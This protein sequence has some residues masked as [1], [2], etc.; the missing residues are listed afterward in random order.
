MERILNLTHLS[1]VAPTTSHPQHDKRPRPS[2]HSSDS[3]S[4]A[5]H[6][7]NSSS[8]LLDFELPMKRQVVES[9]AVRSDMMSLAMTQV[10]HVNTPAAID[11]SPGF[12]EYLLSEERMDVSSASDNVH[13]VASLPITVSVGQGMFTNQHQHQQQ[14]QHL[15]PCTYPRGECLCLEES[16]VEAGATDMD[17]PCSLV[18]GDNETVLDTVFSSALM[19]RLY[20]EGVPAE[21]T[22]PCQSTPSPHHS[23]TTYN[24]K[25]E[26]A[27]GSQPNGVPTVTQRATARQGQTG[28]GKRQPKAT[29]PPSTTAPAISRPKGS[30]SRSLS[31]LSVSST[32]SSNVPRGVTSR[33][34]EA[35]KVVVKQR[36]GSQAAEISPVLFLNK[37]LKC[38]NYSSDFTRSQKKR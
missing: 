32:D 17:Y 19:S 6:S 2:P 34:L 36:L 37:M 10:P 18:S 12:P 20:E 30:S 35:D 29:A 1:E 14:Q 5:L 23:F 8:T 38:R 33:G 27:V 4:H 21:N 15:L 22:P 7:W 13:V 3:A 31:S 24:P 25:N 11:A 28:R 9:N 16:L 26:A